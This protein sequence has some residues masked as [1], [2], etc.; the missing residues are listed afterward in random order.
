[1]FFVAGCIAPTVC[2]SSAGDTKQQDPGD[3]ISV[4]DTPYTQDTGDTHTLNI[5]W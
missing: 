1:M 3:T 2:A 5:R 4:G